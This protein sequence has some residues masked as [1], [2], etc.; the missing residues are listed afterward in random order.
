[1]RYIL[2]FTA[3]FSH[4]LKG[5]DGIFSSITSSYSHKIEIGLD[6]PY[7]HSLKF[8]DG[9]IVPKHRIDFQ[10]TL[11][12]MP[13]PYLSLKSK[14]FLLPIDFIDL[15]T[16]LR[17]TFR[18]SNFSTQRAFVSN[19]SVLNIEKDFGTSVNLLSFDIEPTLFYRLDFW[20]MAFVVQTSFGTG[21]SIYNGNIREVIY[22]TFADY[23]ATE[24]KSIFY[25][26][27]DGSVA[28]FGADEDL[29]FG[30][31]LNFLYS[32][33]FRILF[34]D[35]NFHFTY[36]KPFVITTGDYLNLEEILFGVGW[37]F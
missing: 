5:E 23:N 37:S 35:F 14:A 25:V 15:G 34:R 13:S 7:L 18:Y 1:M 20:K 16:Y 32:F 33:E 21:L 28:L 24:D 17:S 27:N 26:G 4:F 3:L 22:P 11:S 9:F 6:Y 12:A 29:G 31:G 36:R 19:G 8:Q 10:N 30:F 2:I